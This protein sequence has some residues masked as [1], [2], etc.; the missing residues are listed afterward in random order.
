VAR[1][2]AAALSQLGALRA[3]FRAAALELAGQFWH[4]LA[5]LREVLAELG[6][7][8]LD[9]GRPR[10]ALLDRAVDSSVFSHA[11]STPLLGEGF[12]LSTTAVRGR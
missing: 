8:G 1:E 6:H 4:A 2:L 3:Q 12:S 5:Q 9:V 11:P 7:A 10:L